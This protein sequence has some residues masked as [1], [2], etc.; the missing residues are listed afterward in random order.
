MIK[1]I[2]IGRHIGL[3]EKF[4]ETPLIANSYGYNIMQIFVS[5]PVQFVAKQ[6]T[7]EELKKFKQILIN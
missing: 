2:L 3:A 7:D 6:R 4:E 5:S 1:D